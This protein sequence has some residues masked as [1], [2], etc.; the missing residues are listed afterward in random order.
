MG[1]LRGDGD[2]YNVDD[3]D[4]WLA[5]WLAMTMKCL[6]AWWWAWMGPSQQASQPGWLL[7]EWMD[8]LL[9]HRWMCV[10]L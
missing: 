9:L 2:D 10:C 8:E 6:P 7:L 3:D 1:E 5:G 4:G